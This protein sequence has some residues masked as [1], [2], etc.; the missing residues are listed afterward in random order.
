MGSPVTVEGIVEKL[1]YP[2]EKHRQIKAGQAEAKG[3]VFDPDSVTGPLVIWRLKGI[4]AL[5]ES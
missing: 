2:V 5:I 1:E 4:S 3:E